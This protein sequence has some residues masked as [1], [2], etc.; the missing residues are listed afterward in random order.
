MITVGDACARLGDSSAVDLVCMWDERYVEGIIRGIEVSIF[1][2]RSD[3]P[4]KIGQLEG[5]CSRLKAKL[6]QDFLGRDGILVRIPEDKKEG[7]NGD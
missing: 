3:E 4:D 2:M 1:V 5:A 6:A 7:L